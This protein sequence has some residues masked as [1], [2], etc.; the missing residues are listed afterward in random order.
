M[1][2]EMGG[3]TDDPVRTQMD[4]DTITPNVPAP[5]A[6]SSLPIP[7]TFRLTLDIP[8]ADEGLRP[9]SPADLDMTPNSRRATASPRI[10]DGPPPTRTRTD[11]GND[12][13]FQSLVL[14]YEMLGLAPPATVTDA[15][16][17]QGKMLLELHKLR[18]VR[19]AMSSLNFDRLLGTRRGHGG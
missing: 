7:D 1:G 18:Q 14:I 4:I 17:E 9:I 16:V 8:P 5:A 19:D 10:V 3:Q 13:A 12:A 2:M 11:N 6:S 15:L